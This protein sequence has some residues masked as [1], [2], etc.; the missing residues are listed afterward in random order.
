MDL[1]GRDHVCAQNPVSFPTVLTLR[2]TGKTEITNPVVKGTLVTNSGKVLRSWTLTPVSG[3]SSLK[4]QESASFEM[5]LDMTA[6]D[7]TAAI[8]IQ[9]QAGSYG[10]RVL[11]WAEYGYTAADGPAFGESKLW[12]QVIPVWELSADDPRNTYILPVLTASYEDRVYQPG[13]TV[14]FDLTVTNINP[15]DTI[16]GIRFEWYPYLNNGETAETPVEVAMPDLKLL[17]GDVRLIFYHFQKRIRMDGIR[18]GNSLQKK[19]Q[20]VSL[21]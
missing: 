4:P 2:N 3:I 11:F 1:Q 13:E 16:S 12:K 9:D 20:T 17:P 7:E 18:K 8:D 14:T 6:E 5:T 21:L 19:V 10:L 15:T